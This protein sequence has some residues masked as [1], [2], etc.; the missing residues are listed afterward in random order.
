MKTTSKQTKKKSTVRSKTRQIV[1]PLRKKVHHHARKILVP[2]KVNSYRPHLIRWQGITAVLIVA[3]LAQVVYGYT[4][5]GNLSVL[6]RVSDIQ[7]V[8]L[9]QDT[10]KERAQAGVP[11]LA[12][13]DKLSEAAFLR[14]QD[15]FEKNYW[16]HTSPTG[17]QPW[18]W[19]ADVGYNYSYAGEN[20]AK[21]YPNAEATVEA[22]MNSP[23]HREN[24]VNGHYTEIGFAV[25]DGS[26]NGQNTTLVV[27]LYGAPV[28]VAAFESVAGASTFQASTVTL[29]SQRPFEYFASAIQS[30]SPVTIIVL[31]LLAVVAVVGVVAHHYRKKLPKN[32][33]QSWK[34]HHGMYT[35]VGMLALGVLIIL[36]T[37]GGTI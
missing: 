35:F 5:T 27:A 14:A 31:V 7:A 4:T 24:I 6:G 11:E 32:W 8:E 21:N 1:K 3:V 23:S 17:V 25:V 18:K 30:L 26:L 33:R 12:L 36:A 2:H 9:F 16:S 13:N 15:M 20:L 22:W 19:F 37:G 29:G 34:A 10:N 28:T